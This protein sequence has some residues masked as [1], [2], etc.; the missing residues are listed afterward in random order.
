MND[1][2]DRITGDG[3][4]TFRDLPGPVAEATDRR[5]GL[6]QAALRRVATL[7]AEGVSVVDLFGAVAEEVA[8]VLDVS[9]VSL[10]RYETEG[11]ATVAASLHAPAFSMGSRWP[12][13]GPSVSLKVLE[14]GR[15][16]RIDDYTQ[17][18][19]AIAAGVR[20]SGLRSGVGAPILVDGDVWGLIWVA[21]AGPSRCQPAPSP[22]C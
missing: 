16:A 11:A 21:T 10:D 22:A 12:L 6:E 9:V 13:D 2:P 15:P 20:S 7:V 19:G 3:P 4:L 5:T 8:Q 14:T 18:E 17:L 1:P